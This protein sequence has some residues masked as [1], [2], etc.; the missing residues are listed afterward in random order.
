MP[1]K[2]RD[3]TWE[4]YV[5]RA[6]I[7]GAAA[8]RETVNNAVRTA[9]S[10][11]VQ[12]RFH[13]SGF[14]REGVGGPAGQIQDV[15]AQNGDVKATKK[16]T[17]E[18]E[19]K[20]LLARKKLEKERYVR[21]K[22]VPVSNRGEKE[23]GYIAFLKKKKQSNLT[24]QEI[25]YSE[26][27]F[28]LE[29]I[30]GHKVDAIRIMGYCAQVLA[31]GSYRCTKCGFSSEAQWPFYFCNGGLYCAEH[32]PTLQMCMC[33]TTLRPET[34]EVKS[35]DGRVINICTSCMKSRRF[36][37]D[38]GEKMED[39][40]LEVYKCKDCVKVNRSDDGAY[41]DFEWS[42]KWV[43]KN[44]GKIYKSE[45][46]FSCELEAMSPK[47]DFPYILNKE[48]PEGTGI[49][50]DGS[51]GVR[52]Q[53]PW[54]FEVQTPRLL[55]LKGEECIELTVAGIKKVD[56]T[57]DETCGMHI[58][59]DWKGIIPLNRREY[60]EAAIQ[61]L[62]SY[63]AFEDVVFS[64]LPYS[65]R[66]NDYCR[67]LS[68]VMQLS[69]FDLLESMEDIEKFWYKEETGQDIHNSKGHQYHTTRYFGANFHSLFKEGH[70]EIRFHTGTLNRKK[71]LEWAN[72]HALI[73]DAC[74]KKLITSE[75]I[76]EYQKSSRLS[77]RTK[78]LFDK[79][80]LPQSSQEWFFSR[81]K[82]FLEKKNQE[83]ELSQVKPKKKAT[84]PGRLIVPDNWVVEAAPMIDIERAMLQTINRIVIDEAN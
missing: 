18:Q 40:Y 42:T 14:I 39:A 64:F 58:H 10:W 55:G 61:L 44:K 13:E 46:M 15:F 78:L 3:E 82:H 11:Y 37:P 73:L 67:R 20:I 35:F 84:G 47:K 12:G 31:D 33:C 56:P 50:R 70:F 1:N 68:T 27:P 69:E 26:I 4:Q 23:N 17:P 49:G 51:V 25:V 41:R 19:Q 52:D 60:P 74:E 77:E 36:C 66:D 30:S 29:T 24:S 43:S 45:R 80:E 65:R 38:C 76:K 22:S 21:E 2:Y 48:L 83:E 81:Q 8:S 79:I 62:K 32:V 9:Q 71:I 28:A 75:F 54:G 59:L 34:Q 6:R 63:V 53:S 16:I 5:V 57:M 7:I 72:L